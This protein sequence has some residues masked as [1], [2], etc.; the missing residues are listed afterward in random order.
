MGYRCLDRQ[1]TA[2]FLTSLTNPVERI[3]EPGY[4]DRV[5]RTPAEFASVWEHSDARAELLRDIRQF[6][7]DYP[8]GGPT[9]DQFKASRK[10]QK[11]R[12][13]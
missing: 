4:E 13:M 9:L 1:T 2:D 10:A 3:V 5:P 7:N 8:I 6:N 12:W 11:A